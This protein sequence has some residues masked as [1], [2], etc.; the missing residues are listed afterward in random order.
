M[1]MHTGKSILTGCLPSTRLAKAEMAGT[2]ALAE[3]ATATPTQVHVG[4][5]DGAPRLSQLRTASAAVEVGIAF[6]EEASYVGIA[7]R[8]KIGLLGYP[9]CLRVTHGLPSG[10]LGYPIGLWVT[11]LVF[12]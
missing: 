2:S 3:A 11:Q 12:G 5:A 7:I 8:P 9:I 1:A 6:F 4:F 10:S